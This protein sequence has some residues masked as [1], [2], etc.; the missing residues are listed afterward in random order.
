MDNSL[1]LKKPMVSVIMITYGHE[2]FIEQAING[3]L[4]Q[5][6]DF[7]V[8]LIIGNDCSP[9]KTDEVIKKIKKNHPKSS[10][11]K[12][13]KHDKNIGA[14]SNF[15]YVMNEARGKYIALCEGDDYW[16]DP[17]KLQKQ[18]DFLE[19]Y[20]EYVLSFTKSME[21]FHDKIIPIETVYPENIELLNFQK[22]LYYDWFIRTGTIVFRKNKLDINFLSKL[23]YSADYFLQLLLINQGKFHFL[24]EITSVYRH[25]LGGI[26]NS[27]VDLFLERRVW[28]CDNLQ[29]LNDH[30]DY[31]H[32]KIIIENIKKIELDILEKAI[33]NLKIKY[34]Y[35]IRIKNIKNINLHII[36]RIKNKFF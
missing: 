4:M 10:W 29:L 9:D 27:T 18:V 14:M 36:K 2:S 26:S 32:N 15:I 19:N 30:S 28:F 7:E 3:V 25:H 17:Q 23:Q 31:E 21:L 6:C 11:L 13:I 33:L 5:E 20:D 34:I 22:L 12:Y 35:L 24:G 8:E 1:I 16:T